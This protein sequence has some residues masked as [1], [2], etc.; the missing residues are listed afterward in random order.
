MHVRVLRSM[1]GPLLKLSLA[2]GSCWG[3][4]AWA[5]ASLPEGPSKNLVQGSCGGCHSI[6][7]VMQNHLSAK[8]WDKMITTMQEQN[9]MWLLPSEM[10]QEIVAYLAKHFPETRNPRVDELGSRNVNPLGD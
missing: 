5:M 4:V 10:R 8:E 3:S 9:G 2:V 1:S 6:A 7:M